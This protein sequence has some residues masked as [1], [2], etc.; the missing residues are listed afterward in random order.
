MVKEEV[1]VVKTPVDDDIIAVDHANNTN[2]VGVV[3]D[4]QKGV[5]N[6]GE[7]VFEIRPSFRQK[8][9][10]SRITHSEDR[11]GNCFF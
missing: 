11:K 6:I 10:A 1:G 3:N 9:V 7:S 2:G 8:L 5:A 4:K